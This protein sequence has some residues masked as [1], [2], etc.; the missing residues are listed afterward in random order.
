MMLPRYFLP[1]RSAMIVDAR[2]ICE[3]SG[4]SKLPFPVVSP[5]VACPKDFVPAFPKNETTTASPELPVSLL[6]RM[7]IGRVLLKITGFDIRNPVSLSQ[8]YFPFL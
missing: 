1:F 3:P 7:A 6:V 2:K 4:K 8:K 5:Q